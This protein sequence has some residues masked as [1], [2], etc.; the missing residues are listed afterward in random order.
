MG[1][2]KSWFKPKAQPLPEAETDPLLQA[3]AAAA[4]ADRVDAAQQSTSQ[5]SDQLARLFGS[6]A[7]MAGS[8]MKV[9]TLGY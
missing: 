5:A 2:L 9:P 4:K 7:R 6:R 1:F 3:Q 8:G